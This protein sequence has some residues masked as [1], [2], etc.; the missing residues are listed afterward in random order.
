M[1]NNPFLEERLPVGVAMGS[2]YADEYSVEINT[3]AGLA[4]HRHLIQP[5]PCRNFTVSYTME[6]AAYWQSILNLYHRAFGMYKGFR[7]KCL[8]DFSS[9]NQVDAPT[10][11]DMGMQTL[12]PGVS[13]Q[14]QKFYGGLSDDGPY[15]TIFKPIEDSIRIGVRDFYGEFGEILSNWSV[16]IT[17]GIVTFNA[18]IQRTIT[19]FTFNPVG[20]QVTF[21]IGAHPYQVGEAL[22]ISA[23]DISVNLRRLTIVAIGANSV[24]LAL[25]PGSYAGL[26]GAGFVNL[27]PGALD[28]PYAGFEFDIPCRFN[29]RVGATIAAVAVLDSGTIDIVE[30]IAP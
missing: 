24:T 27:N 2:D 26:T 28:S 17:T 29:S 15:R 23:N 14:L 13:Y 7:V 20:P 18:D 6:T 3:T 16:D 4:E 22:L 25:P 19:G 30:L 9:N 21:T 10:P 11:F 5:F 1:S 12:D 8:D